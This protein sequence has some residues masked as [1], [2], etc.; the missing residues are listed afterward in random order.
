MLIAAQEKVFNN[1][2]G[3]KDEEQIQNYL[4]SFIA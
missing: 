2:K 1:N 4:F 3:V